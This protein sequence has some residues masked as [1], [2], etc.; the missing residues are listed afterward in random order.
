MKISEIQ[1]IPELEKAFPKPT[2]YE[3]I[4]SDIAK[5]GIQESV[6]TN[7]ANQL[8]CGYTR[9]SIAEELGIDEIPHRIVDVSDIDAMMEYAILDNIRRRQLTDLQLVEYG[10][11]LEKIYSN[12]QGRPKKGAQNGHLF[13]G[14]TRN[15]VAAQLSK[16]TDTKM[17]ANKYERLKTIATK[18]APEVKQKLNEGEITQKMALEVSKIDNHNK[19]VEIISKAKD[20]LSVVRAV[21]QIKKQGDDKLLPMVQPSLFKTDAVIFCQ[22]SENMD[23]ELIDIDGNK[24]TILDNSVHLVVTSPPYNADKKY[25]VYDDNLNW[26]DYQA[27]LRRVFAQCY[28]KLVVGGRIAVNIPKIILLPDVGKKYLV[29][30]IPEILKEVGFM[31]RCLITWVKTLE[32]EGEDENM[33]IAISAS[34]T[35]WGSWKSP[36]DPALRPQTEFIWVCEKESSVLKSDVEP[37]ITEDEFKK[38]TRD[39]WFIPAVSDPEHPAV[40]PEEL[41]KRLIKLYSYPEQTILDPF[42]GTGRTGVVAIN[43]RFIGFDI[44]E[45]YCRIAMNRINEQKH[46]S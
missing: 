13:Q 34:S 14:K 5:R 23:G 27:L 45:T 16:Q 43:R 11:L 3:E 1:K 10:M 32:K 33:S 19:Q 17:S 42:M 28:R 22:S 4:K 46:L 6:V 8:I 41:A 9:L 26:E 31:V 39:V 21:K 44:S 12:R 30:E 38:W 7:T 36:S 24:H 25:D 35:A 18:A 2:N 15:L 37:D 40:F 29:I 20:A